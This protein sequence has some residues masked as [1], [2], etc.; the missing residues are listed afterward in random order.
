VRSPLRA[1][2]ILLSIHQL[3]VPEER[4]IRPSYEQQAAE[5]FGLIALGKR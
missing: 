3:A 2:T 5:T 1:W 4:D